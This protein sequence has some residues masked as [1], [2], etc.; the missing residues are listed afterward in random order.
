MT[1]TPVALPGGGEAKLV[2]ETTLVISDD[3]G[4]V[5]SATVR[6]GSTLKVRSG[7]LE[8]TDTRETREVDPQ[9]CELT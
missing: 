5:C 1:V 2:G 8:V 3:E 9:T 6:E 7:V 4:Q